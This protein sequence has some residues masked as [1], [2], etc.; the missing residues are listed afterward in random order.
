[1]FTSC[2]YDFTIEVIISFLYFYYFIMENRVCDRCL[3][4]FGRFLV[5]LVGPFIKPLYFEIFE[6][7]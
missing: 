2:L 4:N 5:I 1:M 6:Y 3:K 7:G